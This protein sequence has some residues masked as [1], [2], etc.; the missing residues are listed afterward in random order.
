[1]KLLL[2]IF[3]IINS[4]ALICQ[5]IS[6]INSTETITYHW[7]N[8][9]NENQ[10]P[11][12]LNTQDNTTYLSSTVIYTTTILNLNEIVEPYEEIQFGSN[13]GYFGT[14]QLIINYNTQFSSSLATIIYIHSFYEDFELIV[15]ANG[16]D[17]KG[18]TLRMYQGKYPSKVSGE[19][20]NLGIVTTD[21]YNYN[22]QITARTFNLEYVGNTRTIFPTGWLTSTHIYWYSSFDQPVGLNTQRFSTFKCNNM[23]RVFGSEGLSGIE[24]RCECP[25]GFSFTTDDLDDG[26]ICKTIST[27]SFLP[28][29]ARLYLIASDFV[30]TESDP[31]GYVY[32]YSYPN[33]TYTYNGYNIHG[34]S[35]IST[36]K[37]KGLIQNGIVIA[38]S[39]DQK[40]VFIFEEIENKQTNETIY[41][42]YSTKDIL[43]YNY[44]GRIPSEEYPYKMIGIFSNDLQFNE[45]AFKS[46]SQKS[47]CQ[48]G[49]YFENYIICYKCREDYYLFNGTCYKPRDL[50]ENCTQIRNDKCIH[51]D[52][53][54][55][56]NIKTGKCENII[57]INHCE[58]YLYN[59]TCMKCEKGYHTKNGIC[60][61]NDIHCLYYSDQ[62][63]LKCELGFKVIN[64]ECIEST[65]ENEKKCYYN[66]NNCVIC[67]YDYYYDRNKKSCISKKEKNINSYGESLSCETNQY[68]INGMCRECIKDKQSNYCTLT[69]QYD[70]ILNNTYLENNTCL[71]SICISNEIKDHNGQCVSPIT[72]CNN[73]VNRKCIDC[74]EGYMTNRNG[75][76]EI[77]SP[78]NN[79]EIQNNQGCLRCSNGLFTNERY[80]CQVC[81]SNCE[82]CLFNQSYCLSCSSDKYIVEYSYT[83]ES[84]C[85]SNDKLVDS[86]DKLIITGQG[87]ALCK[88]GW[89]K[90]G[91]NCRKCSEECL[92]CNNENS[93]FECKDDYFMNI[94][95]ECQ[96][97]STIIGCAVNVSTTY[98]C[99]QCIQGY[100]LS[101][102]ECFTCLE[103]CKT[104]ENKEN[105]L[106][107]HSDK[108][109]K[110]GQCIGLSMIQKCEEIKGS[111]CTKCSFWHKPSSDGTLCEKH[112]EIWVIILIIICIL[113][114]F[115]GGILLA[116]WIMK[117]IANKREH[118]EGYVILRMDETNVTMIEIGHGLSTN[119]RLLDIN[120]NDPIPINEEFKTILCVG[121]IGSKAKIIQITSIEGNERYE[122][123]TFPQIVTLKKGQVCEFE[124]YV[125]PLCTTSVDDYITIISTDLKSGITT[126]IP[127]AIQFETEIS[128]QLDPNELIEEKKLGEGSFGVVYRGSFRGNRVAI[129]KMKLIDSDDKIY[130]EFEKEVAMLE[131]FR[132]DYIIHFYGAV[133][134]PNKLAIVTEYAEFKSMRDLIIKR[135][136]YPIEIFMRI[137]LL[138][139]AAKGIQ[140]LH[141]NGILHRDIKPENFLVVSLNENVPINCKLSDFGSARNINLLMTN[142]T[143]T[144]GI[145]TPAYMA[146]EI[147]NR[148]K[149]KKPADI[150]S[151]AITMLELM[152]WGNSFPANEFKFP[153]KIA[154]FVMEGNRPK[155]INRV[156][157]VKMKSL[158]EHCW[159][160]ETNERFQISQIVEYLGSLLEMY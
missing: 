136:D 85:E 20:Y 98:G 113:I 78:L 1:M 101:Q 46:T 69:Q 54:M 118:S 154:E 66:G 148:Q 117:F 116:N 146:P 33:R 105:C 138:F 86:C 114:I 13:S 38:S 122:I 42:M 92:T 128:T 76:C 55:L 40:S 39:N 32:I 73:I 9:C 97:K 82:T 28:N 34:V 49:D 16:N 15:H 14:K 37:H 25:D 77:I 63:C 12:E 133:F 79:C 120:D 104:C 144:K 130:D 81:D 43:S 88:N 90:D 106:T 89:F 100:Y 7:Q 155:T 5:E 151:F 124:V 145:G 91:L 102:K 150:Y 158:I 109:F 84:I 21:I 57:P 83:N 87:C 95:N 41:L 30:I 44:L 149:Y 67:D 11:L 147:L 50:I 132:C 24:Y 60:I 131:K 58:K 19:S 80:Q 53:G 10:I 26:E 29:T 126:Q 61:E 48:I 157:H 115:I 137:K 72:H 47:I 143:F 93:C 111:K 134:I 36:W 119:T 103:D 52:K 65:T 6:T 99:T 31:N 152:I 8:K 159:C 71:S 121:N 70:C 96:L 123:R 94:N 156:S 3:F 141:E 135:Q 17:Q 153:W 45:N 18:V 139:D 160:H 27:A 62:H 112:A 2:F 22:D 64:G 125:K 108:V 107:C 129:K 23:Y 75:G 142:M 127:I 74:S 51:C 59:D 4:N 56:P 35:F 68:L 110:N 140:Y